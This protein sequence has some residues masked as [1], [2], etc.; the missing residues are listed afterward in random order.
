MRF[1][2]SVKGEVHEHVVFTMIVYPVWGDK[3]A[4]D[5]VRS[6]GSRMPHRVI[7]VWH[8]CVFC[9]VTKPRDHHVPSRHGQQ[10]EH[11]E[12]PPMPQQRQKHQQGGIGHEKRNH[13]LT[14]VLRAV[15]GALLVANAE[16]ERV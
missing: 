7:M 6:R 13:G 10:P 16:A 2:Q 12:G 4:L 14:R 9:D 5:Q 1:R 11:E 15:F 3:H 8:D